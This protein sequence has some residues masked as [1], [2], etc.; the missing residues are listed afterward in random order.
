MRWLRITTAE[1]RRA[2][3]AARNAAFPEAPWTAEGLAYFLQSPQWAVG[4][5]CA[6]F[7]GER[8]VGSVLAYWDPHDTGP[9]RVGYTEEVFTLAPWRGRGIARYLLAHAL[10][11]L[12]THGVAEA[13][14]QVRATN[15]GAL[16]VYTGLGYRLGSET[17]HLTQEVRPG[18]AGCGSQ[19]T[20]PAFTCILPFRNSTDR[21]RRLEG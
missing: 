10:Q 8:L 5:T 7:D 9:R 21:D 20:P 6:A 13:H 15:S 16:G 4:T 19:L 18:A 11:Y 17:L 1:E 2:Y 12:H 3:L 14:L